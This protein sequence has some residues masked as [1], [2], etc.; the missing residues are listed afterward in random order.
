M[1]TEMTLFTHVRTALARAMSTTSWTLPAHMSLLTGRY[2][3]S[4]GVVNQ[5][6]RLSAAVPTLTESLHQSGLTTA[7]M[8]S[9]LFLGTQYGFSR[10]FDVYDDHTIPSGTEY[11]ALHDEPASVLTDLATKWLR[12]QG[13]R[14]FFLFLHFWDVHYDYVPPAGCNKRREGAKRKVGRSGM[15]RASARAEEVTGSGE[16]ADLSTA[17]ATTHGEKEGRFPMLGKADQKRSMAC[18]DNIC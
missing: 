16:A 1:T 18:V 4:H 17:A 5:T 7:G 3:L 6:D 9:M 14:R 11:G 2:V 10:G 15:P 13:E 8:V 12:A